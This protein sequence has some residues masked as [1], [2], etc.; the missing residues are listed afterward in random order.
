MTIEERL[1]L[2]ERL[3]VAIKNVEELGKYPNSDDILRRLFWA[4]DHHSK[5]LY[6]DGVKV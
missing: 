2:I 6:H 1:A 5:G 3:I 4:L